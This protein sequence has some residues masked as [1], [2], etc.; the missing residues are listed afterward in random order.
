MKFSLPAVVAPLAVFAL[1]INDSSAP[2]GHCPSSSVHLLF[3]DYG[4]IYFG[5]ST[6]NG[7]LQQGRTAE[8]IARNFGQVTPEYSMKWDAVEP[9]RGSFDFGNSD[10]LVSWAQENGGK[11][12]R[13]HTLLWWRSLPDWVSEIKDPATLTE[14]IETHIG[15]VVGRYRGMVR[16][17]DVVNEPFNDD[18]TLRSTPF[19][20]VLGEDYIGIAFRAARAADPYAKLYINEYNLDV[21]WWDK[22]TS[23]VAKVNQWIDEG[24]PI[25]GIGS[26][27]H[28]VP[29]MAGDIQGALKTL[30]SSSVSE[31]AITELDI[32]TAPPEDYATVV[33]ACINVPK[34][35]GITVWGISD[36]DSWKAEKQPL[37]Y[38]VNYKPKPAY[39]SIISMLRRGWH[40]RSDCPFR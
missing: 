12:I 14:V 1:P 9:V 30:A 32:D 26:Q 19:S 37:L 5:A 2:P 15:T 8:I 13:G 16:S 27:T 3:Q 36:K 31:V 29:G 21:E 24:I 28:L 20:D 34:C 6:D 38:D 7:I 35:V 4:K 33:A 22:V 23:V 25:D 39:K 17:W 10:Y 18:G 40:K 11:V